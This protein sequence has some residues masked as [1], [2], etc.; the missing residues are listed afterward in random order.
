[1][2]VQQEFKVT[3]GHSY[4]YDHF[5]GRVFFSNLAVN[6]TMKRNRDRLLCLLS[7]FAPVTQFLFSLQVV[8]Y[9]ASLAQ[10]LFLCHILKIL[11]SVC[12][13]WFSKSLPGCSLFP[14]SCS[15]KCLSTF[16]PAFVSL[17]AF[18][19]LHFR[20]EWQ[21][22]VSAAVTRLTVQVKAGVSYVF[23]RY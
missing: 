13:F 11:G 18:L 3:K 15:V 20:H 22:V 12:I 6:K 19:L 4:K 21:T 10:F 7:G 23:T 16:L 8:L 2:G 1:M 14:L 17:T 5:V 9:F